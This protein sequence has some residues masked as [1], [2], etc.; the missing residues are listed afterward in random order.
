MP[1]VRVFNELV[2]PYELLSPSDNR[3]SQPDVA[4]YFSPGGLVRAVLLVEQA[5]VRTLHEWNKAS[6]KAAE[7]IDRAI[8]CVTARDV[9]QLEA[10]TEH[11]ITAIVGCIK[12]HMAAETRDVVHAGA[13]SMD[14]KITGEM[15][16]YKAAFGQVVLPMALEVERLLI[17]IA[18]CEAET[19]Q[20]MRT[21]LKHA[22]PGTF[23][24][25]VSEYV[26]RLGDC[27]VHMRQFVDELRGKF[28]GATGTY[29]ALQILLDSDDPMAPIN[30]ERQL[31]QKLGLE[32]AL[33]STQLPSVEPRVRLMEEVVTMAW[34]LVNLADDLRLLCSEEINEVILEATEGQDGSSAM[35]QKVNPKDLE[36]AISQ[37]RE[38][39]G[40]AV[41]VH[42]NQVSNFQRDL[43]D[44]A[45]TRYYGEKVGA[46][47]TMM[48]TLIDFL[49]ALKLNR[50]SLLRNLNLTKGA[51]LSEAA[52]ALL[53]KY[54]FLGADAKMRQ[55]A[56]QMRG[57]GK[58][59][60]AEML[61]DEELREPVL[62]MKDE[63]RQLIEDPVNY[64]GI[65]PEKALLVADTWATRLGLE[66]AT[67]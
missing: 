57:S 55:I 7:D 32:P 54:G 25:A 58:T 9:A 18:R 52:K 33:M 40:V 1:K 13:T 26:D 45:A 59:L 47:C 24:F 61:D 3:Y 2:D 41:T 37:G 16:A 51:V 63:D 4:R 19:R 6:S 14:V 8:T 28:S 56:K 60:Y 39:I 27:I 48:E 66:P 42:L 12:S 35:P 50:E 5:H 67:T 31:L 15:V 29:A 30:Y 46:L 44:S 43:A 36:N 53:T 23:G 38:I 17:K 21:H 34:A 22:V 10:K 65:A 64:V 62:A 11:D 20:I 49:G